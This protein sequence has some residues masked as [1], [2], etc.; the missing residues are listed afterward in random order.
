MI[1]AAKT[2]TFPGFPQRGCPGV[3]REPCK[4]WLTVWSSTSLHPEQEGKGW[5]DS[6]ST[7]PSPGLLQGGSRLL[8]L[9]ARHTS[10]PK[11]PGKR[12]CSGGRRG[13]D[14][15]GPGAATTRACS[16][17]CP[18][19]L[20]PT[21][22]QAARRRPPDGPHEPVCLSSPG[23]Q[24]TRR[25]Q[26]RLRPRLRPGARA[27][28]GGGRSPGWGRPSRL[29][30]GL[31]GWWGNISGRRASL[32]PE[33]E[34]SGSSGQAEIFLLVLSTAPVGHIFRLA[35]SIFPWEGK[36]SLDKEAFL[37]KGGDSVKYRF[38][39]PCLGNPLNQGRTSL[40]MGTQTFAYMA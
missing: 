25:P 14:G 19:S 31:T 6:G 7:G 8:W 21:A 4:R 1:C 23:R 30:A 35:C 18:P 20:C 33:Q 37:T 27:H 24:S 28:G 12:S 11:L 34:P 29:V 10:R 2:N 36:L 26:G 16:R 5:R 3:E 15:A 22:P 13:S 39:W 38:H 9:T 32:Q 17:P 40:P